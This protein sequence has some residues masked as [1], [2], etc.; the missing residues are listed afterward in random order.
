MSRSKKRKLR[1]TPL[2]NESDPHEIRKLINIEQQNLGMLEQVAY[3]SI[4]D[5]CCHTTSL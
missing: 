1:F 2:R 4:G 3:F 5:V